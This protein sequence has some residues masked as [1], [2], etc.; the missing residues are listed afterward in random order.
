MRV[1]AIDTSAGTSVAVVESSGASV[2]V[3]GE[4]SV[5]N[6]MKHAESIGQAIAD[7]LTQAKSATGASATVISAPI[8]GIDAVVVGRGP[9]PFT[10]LRVGIAAAIM[11]AEGLNLPLFGVVSHDAVALAEFEAD[12]GLPESQ[13]LLV[14]SDA[15]RNEVYWAT[16][17]SINE[18]GMPLRTAGPAVQKPAELEAALA[19]A[20]RQVVRASRAVRAADIAKVF[21]AQQSSGCADRDV[22]ALYLRAPDAVPT[23]AKK[24]SG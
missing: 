17:S 22:S 14:T 11:F 4:A 18:H 15:R 8:R 1:L 13:E 21:F 19:Q 24:V 3:L 12:F 6:T 16:Y 23:A 7:A 9:A 2:R 20:G 10:G 5:E